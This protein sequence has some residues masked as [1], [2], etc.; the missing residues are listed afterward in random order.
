MTDFVEQQHTQCRTHLIAFLEIQKT[1]FTQNEHY[2]EATRLKWLG[3]YK[4]GRKAKSTAPSGNLLEPTN[5][6]VLSADATI[7]G[8]AQ[9]AER[10]KAN[11]VLGTG[12]FGGFNSNPSTFGLS[13]SGEKQPSLFY[14]PKPTSNSAGQPS[15]QNKTP[16]GNIG[17]NAIVPPPPTT[18]TSFTNVF[19]TPATATRPFSSPQTLDDFA[20][21][22]K[23][24]VDEALAALAAIGYTGLT[25]DDLGKLNPEDEYETEL[26]VMAEVRA[27]FQVSYKVNYCV[28]CRYSYGR[29]D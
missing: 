20:K 14:N 29:A 9:D 12:A 28:Y 13:F 10:S 26:E 3:R 22:D 1:P 8:L 18:Q 19:G 25:T 6:F 16:N 21:K 7:S 2:F 24:K 5:V 17:G 15:P 4:D 23:D 27:Y 11:P